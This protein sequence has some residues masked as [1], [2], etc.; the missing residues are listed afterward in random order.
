MFVFTRFFL[1]IL[2]TFNFVAIYVSKRWTKFSGALNI[3]TSEEF[4]V[5]WKS[6]Q[7][8]SLGT[9]FGVKLRYL[10]HHYLAPFKVIVR[11]LW[12]LICFWVLVAYIVICFGA[13]LLSDQYKTA[14]FV[15]GLCLQ[16]IW[17]IILIEGPDL[18]NILQ[19][20]KGNHSKCIFNCQTKSV[21]RD[22]FRNL[23][24]SS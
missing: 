14:C 21:D 19:I 6:I 9:R 13:P 20:I 22:S 5:N 18:Q 4:S 8:K 12:T 16:S 23:F 24:S 7:K 10:T 1:Q 11:Y 3:P 2:I 17:P 15:T